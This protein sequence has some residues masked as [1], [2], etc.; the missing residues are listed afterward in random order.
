[1]FFK[2]FLRIERF[3][4]H[5]FK[6]II[7]IIPNIIPTFLSGSSIF[8]SL[9]MYVFPA[10][11]VHPMKVDVWSPLKSHYMY[12]SSVTGDLPV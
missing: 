4:F 9:C 2:H 1:M 6:V 8:G 11:L 5:V 7:I 3:I 10:G 12:L